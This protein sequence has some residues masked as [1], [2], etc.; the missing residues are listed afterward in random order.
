MPLKNN[1]SSPLGSVIFA[2][3]DSEIGGRA[4]VQIRL[5]GAGGKSAR[6]TAGQ[7][8]AKMGTACAFAVLVAA[9]S[10]SS[11]P[12]V[13]EVDPYQP[14][15]DAQD[16]MHAEPLY[17]P[18][19]DPFTGQSLVIAQQSDGVRRP[20]IRGARETQT[21]SVA[22]SSQP[23]YAPVPSGGGADAARYQ[24][25]QAQEYQQGAIEAQPTLG[26]PVQSYLPPLAGAPTASPTVSVTQQPLAQHQQ[27]LQQPFAEPD[28]SQFAE[29]DSPSP[30]RP[31][32]QVLFSIPQGSSE[33]TV[34]TSGWTIGGKAVKRA[35]LAPPTALSQS[36]Q[37]DLGYGSDP[38]EPAYAQPVQP[39]AVAPQQSFVVAGST[40]TT[41][42]P[43]AA[44]GASIWQ[45]STPSTPQTHQNVQRLDS[46]SI[47]GQPAPETAPAPKPV[48]MQPAPQPVTTIASQTPVPTERSQLPALPPVAAVSAP[49]VAGSSA[50]QHHVQ[51]G[52]TLY[53]ISRNTGVP[54]NDLIQANGLQP[55]YH[56]RIGQVLSL[57]K[58]APVQTAGKAGV[59]KPSDL[60][61]PQP[62]QNT[63]SVSP[64]V[65]IEVPEPQP[66]SPLFQGAV[67][68]VPQAPIAAG[69]A[70][71]QASLTKA[72]APPA[73][74]IAL[75]QAPGQPSA[76]PVTFLA[77]GSAA[78]S[79]NALTYT[80]KEPAPSRRQHVV[81]PG[82]TLYA[83]AR[84]YDV[85]VADLSALN[86]LQ[87]PY[88]IRLN[89]IILVPPASGVG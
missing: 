71:S 24:P 75:A 82:D 88:N 58:S 3:H 14:L 37:Q 38:L 1:S 63:G 27:G 65:N 19:D 21:T 77:S 29:V 55:P 30:S 16:Q 33:G 15:F 66:G 51:P 59:L 41:G 44:S 34:N 62:S 57:S 25:Y 40:Q 89:Q 42:V 7:M 67:N 84:A 72:S 85:K 6:K 20:T 60:N 13:S 22:A 49:G 47:F 36:A 18:L 76:Q 68:P 74:S 28:F 35:P 52:E 4:G 53:A 79:G 50:A 5:R 11:P 26:G 81:G 78:S 39:Q 12:Q 64:L 56:I 17:P 87:A 73:P 23:S 45:P 69:A 70:P 54:L 46:P 8:V 48:L 86:G 10:Q 31:G 43:Q 2:E 61:A 9:C 80:P 83:I 32:E